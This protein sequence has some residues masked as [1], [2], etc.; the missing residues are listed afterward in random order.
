MSPTECPA[1]T[2]VIKLAQVVAGRDRVKLL[3]VL[4][5]WN[6]YCCLCVRMSH[7]QCMFDG[8][9]ISRETAAAKDCISPPCFASSGHIVHSLLEGHVAIKIKKSCTENNKSRCGTTTPCVTFVQVGSPWSWGRKECPPLNNLFCLFHTC[10]AR[11]FCC[12]GLSAL[13]TV[14]MA[15]C[16]ERQWELMSSCQCGKS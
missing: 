7:R 1:E 6:P 13:P 14:T 15:L 8:L 9:E 12:R 5:G 4:E 3:R 16:N 11:H 10:A 2:C